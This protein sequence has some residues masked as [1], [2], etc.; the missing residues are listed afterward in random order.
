MRQLRIRTNDRS[1]CALFWKSSKLSKPWEM[2]TQRNSHS[3]KS[4]RVLLTLGWTLDQKYWPYVGSKLGWGSLFLLGKIYFVRSR[5]WPNH[6]WKELFV[7]SC[8]KQIQFFDRACCFSSSEKRSLET[9][10]EQACKSKMSSPGLHWIFLFSSPS[11]WSPQTCMGFK[12]GWSQLSHICGSGE[13]LFDVQPSFVFLI[14][15]LGI[16]QWATET[17][18]VCF[19][20][21]KIF[22]TQQQLIRLKTVEN[23]EEDQIMISLSIVYPLNGRMPKKGWA[24][25]KSNTL[26]SIC[27]T[28]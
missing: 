18:A 16:A 2:M 12:K 9:I 5:I 22:C 28:F 4:C 3:L 19:V 24:E 21:G 14:L 11:L 6:S 1:I 7:L 27:S 23:E 15:S 10:S 26:V 17:S 25:W 13:L 8:S 20:G